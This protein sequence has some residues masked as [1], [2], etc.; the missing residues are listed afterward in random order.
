MER[1]V[2]A[3]QTA[4]P[5]FLGD[6]AAWLHDAAVAEKAHVIPGQ[7]VG[8]VDASGNPI[9]VEEL[10]GQSKLDINRRCYGIIIPADELLQR[11]SYKWFVRMSAAQV[12]GSDT[13]IGKIMLA[14][15]SPQ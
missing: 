3:D 15:M 5:D 12:V 4:A 2:S 9:G 7:L 11:T 6:C 1:L 13:F 10:L 8:T 14:A